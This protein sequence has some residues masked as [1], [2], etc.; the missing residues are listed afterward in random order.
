MTRRLVL[1][2]TLTATLAVLVS[3][4]VGLLVV[5]SWLLERVDHQLSALRP[6]PGIVPVPEQ[7]AGA[8][9]S[10]FRIYF[11]DGAGRL[12]GKSD[13]TGPALADDRQHLDVA[14]GRPVTVPAADG[15]GR[16]RILVRTLSDGTTGVVALPLDTVNGA[17]SKLLWID[18]LLLLF[19]VGGLLALSRWV[20]RLGLLPLSRVERTAEEITAGRL[21][22]RLPD[23]DPSTEVGR[24]GRVL[25]SMLDRLRNAL[26]EREA[27]E[28]RL[29]QF[30]ADAGHELRTPLTTIRGYAQLGLRDDEEGYRVIAESSA[31][32]ALL[33]D[34]LQLLATLDREPA[35]ERGQVDLLSLAADAV[36]SIGV[37]SPAH[38]IDLGPLRGVPAFGKKPELEVVQ[39][40]GD[41]RRLRQIVDNLLSNAV[42]YTPTGT[43]VHVRLGTARA[44]AL[45]GGTDRPG[46]VGASAP[47]PVGTPICVLEV[48]DEGPGLAP[49]D[50]AHIF[51][52]FYRADRSRS[53]GLGGSGLGLAIAAVI[54]E[55][56]GGRLELDPV[57]GSGCVFRLVLPDPV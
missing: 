5:R 23:T 21:D 24:L 16:W 25:N 40:V 7:P 22:L 9:P 41:P 29:R 14:F 20:V 43:P 10:E 56:H 19:T 18:G 36:S 4:A 2:V 46:R 37:Q 47:L 11:Y 55:G 54:A 15:D 33:V 32:M 38:P 31:R 8:L 50:A 13:A 26:A 28:T 27:S 48:A 39:T 49:D 51:E 42:R 45:T 35:Y 6:P 17:A 3:Q 34:D 57:P 44:G 1:G 52:R 53:R 12:V 30:V